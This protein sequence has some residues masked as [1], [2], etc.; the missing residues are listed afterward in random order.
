[1][2]QD[3]K[4]VV[5]CCPANLQQVK[6]PFR[7]HVSKPDEINQKVVNLPCLF[8]TAL[9]SCSEEK[10]IPLAK[11]ISFRSISEIK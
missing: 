8:A 9:D 7:Y 4:N 11:G 5:K 6:M 2:P 10:N 3:L 1:M